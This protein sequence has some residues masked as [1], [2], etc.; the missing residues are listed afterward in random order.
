MKNRL[1]SIIMLTVFAAGCT[2][3][4]TPVPEP[5]ADINVLVGTMMAAKLTAI[6]PT[7]APPTETPA[8]EPTAIPL[9]PGTLQEEFGAGFTYP[10]ASVW[11]DPLDTARVNVKHNYAVTAEQD[12]L[13][14]TLNDPETY[15][16]TFYQKEM[17]A[18]VSIET[19]YLDVDTQSSEASVVCRADPS[20]SKFYEF[21]I[22]HFEKAGV[23][24]YFEK[25]LYYD[26]Y[27][28]LAYAKLPVELFKDKE[29]RLEGRCQGDTL[30]LSLNGQQVVSVQDSKIPAGGLVGLGG[31]SHK[32]VPMTISFNYLNV[33]PAQ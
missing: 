13:K 31:M 11:S 27:K 22:V 24:Y 10:N 14:Y 30:T 5:T 18:D 6:A 12:F 8:P 2:P 7:P 15:L 17:P 33:V 29:N 1:I 26:Q 4:P 19:S 9:P 3:Q 28:R 21:R 32:K 20:L 25:S 23:I 16:Y